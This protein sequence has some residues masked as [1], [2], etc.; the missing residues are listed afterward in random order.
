[1]VTI[2]EIWIKSAYIMQMLAAIKKL[3][4]IQYSAGARFAVSDD[5]DLFLE[6]CLLPGIRAFM[7]T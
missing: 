7:D 5:T 1:M 4:E 3:P 2:T 6:S